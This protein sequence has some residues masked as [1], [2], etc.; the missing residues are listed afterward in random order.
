MTEPITRERS[1]DGMSLEDQARLFERLK[2]E[3]LKKDFF[4]LYLDEKAMEDM[5]VLIGP[6]A[7]YVQKLI[8]ESIFNGLNTTTL[9]KE[10]SLRI[11]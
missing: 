8:I 2:T 10:S 1:K 7:N 4:V 3:K 9:I 6:R 11:H 5:E